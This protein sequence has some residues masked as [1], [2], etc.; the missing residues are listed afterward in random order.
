[1]IH[2]ILETYDHD[3]VGEKRFMGACRSYFCS[4]C[5]VAFPQCTSPNDD[6]IACPMCKR[7]T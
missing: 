4:I 6:F 2:N 5:R 7:V 1:M 3:E